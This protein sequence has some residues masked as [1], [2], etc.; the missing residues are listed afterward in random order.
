MGRNV[1]LAKGMGHVEYGRLFLGQ[2]KIHRL[3]LACEL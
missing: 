3:L 1:V 2:G